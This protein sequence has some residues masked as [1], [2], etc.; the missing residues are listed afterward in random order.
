MTLRVHMT[1]SEWFEERAGGLNRYFQDLF[2]ES[3]RAAQFEVTA[4]AFGRAPSGGDSWGPVGASLAERVRKSRESVAGP[5]D[6]LDRHFVP[7]GPS[8]RRSGAHAVVT[9]FQGPWFAE[10]R[11]AG[12]SRWRT[13]L[14]R[15][16]EARR[17]HEADRAVVLC[18][19]F[20]RILS[21][22]LAFP[23]ENVRVIPPGVNLDRFAYREPA[24]LDRPLVLCVR[25][26]ERRMGIDVLITAWAEVLD[27][28]PD[29]VLAI[30]GGG[31]EEAVLRAQ[32][33]GLGLG[34][35]VRMHGRIDDE[36]L[37][38][39][40]RD[41]ALTV[42]PTR[43]LEGFGLIALESLAVG[44]PVIVTR[45]GGLPDAVAGLDE[46]LIVEPEDPSALAERVA[47]ALG[48]QVPSAA[49]CRAHAERFSWAAAVGA[50]AA[51]YRELVS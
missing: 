30:V 38:G 50:H 25:R 17:H 32:V 40:Y 37:L 27:R 4:S 8:R 2:E 26:L 44:R 13:D 41:A 10:S 21:R 12:Q 33:D 36:S 20:G 39:L 15:I 45:V 29:A 22:E 51:L 23:E 9:H 14:K 11:L 46:S 5:L 47:Q 7:Y 19:E 49:A 24:A 31:S 6:V 16:W 1:G 34:G 35:S 28:F 43:D 18:A 42:V 48:G 3:Q